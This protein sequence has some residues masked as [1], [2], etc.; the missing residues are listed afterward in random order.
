MMFFV[1]NPISW[2]IKYNVDLAWKDHKGAIHSDHFNLI[3]IEDLL[4]IKSATVTMAV[5][6][7]MNL[8]ILYKIN[9]Y[10]D[11]KDDFWRNLRVEA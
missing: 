2:H 3:H 1:E 4:L 6:L 5:K 9:V 10:R 7:V 8:K 11:E